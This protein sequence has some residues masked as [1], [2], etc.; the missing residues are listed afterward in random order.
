MMPTPTHPMRVVPGA[1]IMLACARVR[2][3]YVDSCLPACVGGKEESGR[4]G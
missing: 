3:G 2:F 1:M 4:G